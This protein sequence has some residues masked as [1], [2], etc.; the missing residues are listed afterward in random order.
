[1]KKILLLVLGLNLAAFSQNNT[2]NYKMKNLEGRY[3]GKVDYDG[4]KR[5]VGLFLKPIAGEQ[6]S[7]YGVVLEYLKPF[8][9]KGFVGS[10]L[11]PGKK[12][13]FRKGRHGYLQELLKWIKIY[14]FERVHNSRTFRMKP[15]EVR[16]GKVVVKESAEFASL[17][18]NPNERKPM[19]NSVLKTVINGQIVDLK[20]TKTRRFPLKSTWKDSYVPGPYNPGYKQAD[21]D[22]LFLLDDFNKKTKEATAVFDV[23]TL[24][25]RDL[26]IQGRFDII[27]AGPGMFTFQENEKVAS[28]GASL[29]EDK[30]GVFIDVYDASP[31]MKTVELILI[32]PSNPYGSQMY[33]E[34]F[35]NEDKEQ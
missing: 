27:E 14:K 2:S 25:D 17:Q 13:I 29:V 24:K 23:E 33:F 7:Y 18:V 26:L 12:K 30:I 10:F 21:I 31:V 35:G 22:I 16:N 9:E 19:R 4:E 34:E 15:L 3:F 1:M 6:D 5:Q 32:D 11:R 8:K 28:T 20:L